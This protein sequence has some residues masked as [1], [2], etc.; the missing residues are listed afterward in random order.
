MNDQVASIYNVKNSVMDLAVHFGP[1]LLAA[2]VILLL[3]CW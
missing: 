2:L 1:R 3:G